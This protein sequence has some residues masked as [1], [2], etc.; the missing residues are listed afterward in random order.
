MGI[1]D[2]APPCSFAELLLRVSMDMG[3]KV[4]G[5]RTLLKKTVGPWRQSMERVYLYAD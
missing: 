1:G 4:L 2:L 5:S 3:I